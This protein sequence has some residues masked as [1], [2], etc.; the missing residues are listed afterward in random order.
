MTE[1]LLTVIKVAFLAVLWLFIL[2]VASVVRTDLVG[3][4]VPATK[5]VPIPRQT[6]APAPAAVPVAEAKPAKRGRREPRIIAIDTGLQAGARLRL[7]DTVRIGRTSDCELIL[8]DDFVSSRHARLD[9]RPD[10]T[11]V[12]SDLG[13]T[14]GTF[15]NDVR[16]AGPTPVTVADTIRVA[17]VQMRLER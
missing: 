8:A 4:T 10:G 15:V 13:S 11:W 7:V 12:L 9:R 14:N 3:R 16:I 2:L 6:P 5:A 1:L 17:N